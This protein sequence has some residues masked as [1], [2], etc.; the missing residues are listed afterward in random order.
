[1]PAPAQIQPE[2]AARF[3]T[4]S[5]FGPTSSSIEHLVGLKSYESWIDEQANL[6]PSYHRPQIKTALFRSDG[7]PTGQFGRMN[8]WWDITVLNDDQLRQRVAFALS[9]IMVVSDFS[10][11]L[12]L[13]RDMVAD[14]Y[15]I[16][17]RHSLGDFRDL[18]E[19]IT[20]SPAMSIYLS[21]LGND[22]PDSS[23]NRRAD[24]NYARELLQLFSIG[25][26]ELNTNGT[27]RQD[28]NGKP[29]NTYSQE[30]IENLARIFTGWAWNT[31]EYTRSNDVGNKR[32]ELVTKPIIAFS[33]FH[34]QD[35][36]NF[37]GVTFPAGQTANED[38]E[39][40]LDT[41]FNHP[42]VGPFIGKQLIMRLVTS[43]PSPAYVARVA[44]TFNNNGEGIRGDLKAVVKS[45]LL[46]KE[47]RTSKTNYFGKLKEPLIRLTHLWRAFNAS[48]R[49]KSA[50][51]RANYKA[52]HY[53]NPERQLYQAPMR[54]PSVFNFFRPDF[55][56]Y[57]KI[58]SQG[59]IA[60]EFKIISE[61]KLQNADD[62]FIKFVTRGGFNINDPISL[63]LDYEV[64]LIDE[65]EKVIDHLDLLLT[66]GNM[67]N[68]LRQILLKYLNSNRLRINDD[69]KTIQRLISLIISSAEYSIQR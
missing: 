51:R 12:R 47:A 52:F 46:D 15:D 32:P 43:N 3:L 55:S 61:S 9:E 53:Y 41:I 67:S 49:S 26:V 57:G 35:E 64:A 37:L 60:P 11:F 18:L 48:R 38:L 22:K 44:Q 30:D 27:P 1:A 5:T 39:L 68:E 45:I 20:L 7:Q 19:D 56:P 50:P 25:L 13:P 23:I 4:Q 63:N 6:P 33:E 14:Y 16:L 62:T 17:V 28:A 59:L 29:I 65:P 34:D 8:V 40:A 58:K 66:S 21:M 42:N 69:K 31:E 54:A 10:P 2:D 36:K 24:E